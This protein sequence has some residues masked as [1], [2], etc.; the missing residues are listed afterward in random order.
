MNL[1]LMFYSVGLADAN[2]DSIKYVPV[3][4]DDGEIEDNT[5]YKSNLVTVHNNER[6]LSRAQ[7][8]GEEKY[9]DAEHVFL[10]S[11]FSVIKLYMKKYV[12][13]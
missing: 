12:K 11:P 8:M 4:Y 13:Y 10:L 2:S 7:I 1:F 3:I 6:M 5:Y 9:A